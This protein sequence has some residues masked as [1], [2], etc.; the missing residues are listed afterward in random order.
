MKNRKDWK[1]VLLFLI[2][3]YLISYFSASALSNLESVEN[4][5]AV[6]PVEGA[7]S[8]TSQNG[9]ISETPSIET[10]LDNIEKV[11]KDDSIKGVIF[12]INSPGGSAVASQKL[13]DAISSINKPKVALIEEVGASGAYWAAS[14]CDKIVASPLSITGSIGV[15][16]SYL[17]FS[18]LFEKYGITYHGL[19]AGEYKDTG[20]PYKELT[21]KEKKMLEEKINLIYDYFVKEVAK[22]RN[23]S[24]NKVKKLADGSFYLGIEAKEN[25]LIDYT[26]DKDLAVNITKKLINKEDVKVFEFKKKRNLIDYLSRLSSYYIGRGIGVSLREKVE[27][28]ELQIN[29]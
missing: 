16:S 9:I 1:F 4:K 19:K 17:E 24:L 20:S 15:I 8:L 13:A 23:M 25:G 12:K 2:L 29:T 27:L 22:N 10:I 26:G 14:A 21:S 5:I 11:K 6:I 3:L 7:L 28:S 18:E